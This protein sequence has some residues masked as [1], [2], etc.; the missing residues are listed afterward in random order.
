[1]ISVVINCDTRAGYLTSS[2][3]SD[4]GRLSLQGVRSVDFLT[5]GLKQK[6]NYFRGHEI[7]VILYIDMHESIDFNL[8]FDINT[9]IKGCGNNSIVVCKPH[10]RA[11]YKWNDKIYIEALK[12]ATG[13]YVVH[14]DGDANAYR[15]DECDIIDRY[16]EW[17]EVYKYVC[18][19]WDG[20]GDEMYWAS[21]RFFICKRE[22]LDFN[23]IEKSIL[24][25]PLKGINNACLEHTIG[26]LAGDG[27]VLYPQRED[28][29]Y[30]VFSWAR[31]NSGTLKRLNETLP[32]YALK[33]V[34]NELG[35]HGAN[36]CLDKLI[37]N[38]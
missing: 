2:S 29:S 37:T 35:I 12:L 18:Q 13:T 32:K 19:P 26:I 24:I 34:L 30:L 28:E 21:T 8:W 27:N 9:I 25:N 10:E 20:V 33:Y 3:G 14:F 23:E 17:L 22:T 36:D 15:T 38:D 16:L 7:Q 5:E 1:M 31:Y 6:I 4:Y 11:S